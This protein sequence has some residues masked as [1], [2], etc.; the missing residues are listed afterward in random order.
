[1]YF[2]EV[3]PDPSNPTVLYFKAMADNGNGMI[4]INITVTTSNCYNWGSCE[5][6]NQYSCN[7]TEHQVR[8][9][10]EY[11]LQQLFNTTSFASATLGSSFDLSSN[12]PSYTNLLHSYLPNN[13]M[14]IKTTTKGNDELIMEFGSYI[15]NGESPIWQEHCTF[16]V[17]VPVGI[18]SVDFSAPSYCHCI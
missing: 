4:E 14:Y 7:T 11:F 12:F 2:T 17:S 13:H 18:P 15:P 9:N 16:E 1:M 10:L 6:P 3:S 5:L 8:D